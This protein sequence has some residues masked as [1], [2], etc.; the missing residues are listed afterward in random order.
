MDFQEQF[1]KEKCNEC[2]FYHC[3]LFK[4]YEEWLQEHLET[5]LEKVIQYEALIEANAKR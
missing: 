2:H 1:E 4:C 3:E 5:A